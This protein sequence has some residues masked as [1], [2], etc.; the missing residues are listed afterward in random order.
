MITISA[1]IMHTSSSIERRQSLQDL[2]SHL[3][4]QGVDKHW[5]DVKVKDDSMRN[6]AWWNAKR[7]WEEGVKSEAT[8]FIL[9]QDDILI[10]N[11]FVK[12]VKSVI[13]AFPNEIISLFHGPRKGFDGSARW[14]QSEGVWGQGIVMP[15]PMINEFLQWERENIH[16]SFPHDDSRVSLFALKTRRRCFV[17]F[18][19]LIDHR[20]NELSSVMN[21]KRGKPRMSFDFMGG[22]D[23]EDFDWSQKDPMMKSI[24]SFTQYNKYLLNER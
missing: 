23:P 7:C 22:R 6:G 19:N 1:S 17:P 3:Y 5:L 14:G 12:G 2:Y 13:A 15:V 11:N 16:P 4:A 18:P 24:N 10:C 21:N 20:D 8:H 9:M